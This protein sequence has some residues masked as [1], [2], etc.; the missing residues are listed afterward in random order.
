MVVFLVGLKW[1]RYDLEARKEKLSELY[2]LIERSF[3]LQI[4]KF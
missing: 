4:A 2:F 1:T 3:A